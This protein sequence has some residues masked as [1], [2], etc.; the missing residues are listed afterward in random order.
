VIRSDTYYGPDG[1]W[2]AVEI[3][4]GGDASVDD[5]ESVQTSI[6]LIPGKAYTSFVLNPGA[7]DPYPIHLQ[8]IGIGVEAG[9]SPFPWSSNS[10]LLISNIN[11]AEPVPVRMDPVVPYL[12]LPNQTCVAISKILPIYFNQ[13]TRY[14]HWNT[15]DPTYEG[16]VSS[17]LYMS[18]VFPPQ[19]IQATMSS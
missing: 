4:V 2:Q 15:I 7:C 11:G 8:D 18:L 16:V 9:G 3:A 10:E 17:A 12:H 5:I 1:P 19:Q 14:W 6:D 13:T